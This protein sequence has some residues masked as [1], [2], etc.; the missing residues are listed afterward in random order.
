MKNI[1]LTS[2]DA[3][4]IGLEVTAKALEKLGPQ[5]GIQFFLFRSARSEL[6]QLKKIDKNFNRI[7]CS[8]LDEAFEKASKNPTAFFDIESSDSEPRWVE[9]AALACHSKKAAGMVTAPLSKTLIQKAGYQAKGHTEILQKISRVS[10]VHMVF[11]G[12]KFNVLLATGHLPLEKVPK[13]LTTQVLKIALDR[14]LEVRKI[15]KRR[16]QKLPIGLVGLNPHAGESG[17]LGSE[18]IEIFQP[19]VKGSND[20]IGPLPPDAAFLKKNWSRF[21]VFVC[22]YHDQGLIPFKM[23]HGTHGFHLTFGLSF[24]R[25]SVDHGT[26]IDLYGKNK[27]DSSSM[28]DAIKA[29]LEM[30]R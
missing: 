14:A 25:T 8:S 20:I 18:E 24:I 2:G 28:L 19:L 22:P 16:Q 27:A 29:C 6:K 12:K 26:A 13:V 3:N 5:K 23:I 15:L 17:L 1:L 21:S 4:G 7:T 11:I 30:S 9:I 10:D